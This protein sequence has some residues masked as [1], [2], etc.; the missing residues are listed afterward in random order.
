VQE[1]GRRPS[2]EDLAKYM[3]VPL[4]KTREVLKVAQVPISLDRP[5][6]EE[7][8]A[9]PGDFIEDRSIISAAQVVISNNL[10]PCTAAVSKTLSYS[11]GKDQLRCGSDLMMATPTLSRRSARVLR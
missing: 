8:E 2:T 1:F 10:K 4:E 5:I 9:R 3:G 6:G 7:Q 11:R